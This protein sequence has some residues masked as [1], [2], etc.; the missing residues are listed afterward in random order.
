[1][2][3][4]QQPH[5]RRLTWLFPRTRDLGCLLHSPKAECKDD[6]E[7]NLNFFGAVLIIPGKLAHYC[8]PCLFLVFP[9]CDRRR[10]SCSVLEL[11]LIE[12]WRMTS[13]PIPQLWLNKGV[14]SS[15]SLRRCGRSGLFSDRTLVHLLQL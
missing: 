10:S 11:K 12:C 3:H 7:E 13:E 9:I 5:A 6:E 15:Q 4:S 1:M 2:Q 8:V 14:I